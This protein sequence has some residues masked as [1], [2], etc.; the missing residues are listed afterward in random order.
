MSKRHSALEPPLD[1][2]VVQNA[3]SQEVPTEEGSPP[4]PASSEP[5]RGSQR[6][7][8]HN[9]E[10]STGG[11]GRRAL[12]AF[13]LG[14]ITGAADD[15]PSAIGT[16]A[17]AGAKF[18]PSFLWMAPITFPMMI[19]VVYLSGKL[20]Q[21]SGQGLFAL[22]RTHYPKWLLYSTL[23]AVLIGNVIE[24]GADIGGMAAA[25][26]LLVPL[27]LPLVVVPITAGI[28]AFQIWG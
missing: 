14:L 10:A 24:A 18:G 3:R 27:P 21:V 13:G 19:V 5:A 15:D 26:R 25:I 4:L 2:G 12:R 9:I 7:P 20:G 1:A 23:A 28:L 6:A 8:Q 11:R 22:L 16:Y 17:S